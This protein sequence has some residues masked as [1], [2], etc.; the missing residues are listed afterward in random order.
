MSM[1]G[2]RM[3]GQESMHMPN[4]DPSQMTMYLKNMDFPA[5]KQKIMAMAKDK[6]MPEN[7]MQWLNKLPNKQY[8]SSTDVESEFKKMM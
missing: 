7:V 2:G 1:Q 6:G 8:S 3:G 5:D 4:I